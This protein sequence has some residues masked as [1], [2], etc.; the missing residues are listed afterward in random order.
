MTAGFV[1]L[2]VRYTDPVMHLGVAVESL[3]GIV[4]NALGQIVEVVHPEPE[5]DANGVTYWVRDYDIRDATKFAGL[6]LTV[7]WEAVL[8]GIALP[9]FP[10]LYAY[11]PVARKPALATV[12][13]WPPCA[14][15][16]VLFYEITRRRSDVETSIFVGRSFG[17][18][19]I[20]ET[21]FASEFE[22]RSWR[23]WVQQYARTPGFLQ[24]DGSDYAASGGPFEPTR[25][26]RA[27]TPVCSIS[28]RLV[29]I[30]GGPS[31]GLYV[32]RKHPEVIFTVHPK[33]TQ[34]LMGDMYI[35]PEDIVAN[36]GLDGY[37]NIVLLQDVIVEFRVT[38]TYFR[39]KFIVPRRTSAELSDLDI[40]IV[41]DY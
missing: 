26:W 8:R 3:S 14:D 19:Y 39:G 23:Y 41:R 31:V 5:V 34:Q 18:S 9:T 21:V 13:Q 16:N 38:S 37:F 30:M 15:P 17:P 22:A 24:L 33:Q 7:E 12:L 35:M 36:V 20:D 4:R 40:E 29:D 11:A 2:D 6:T 32:D 1:D 28:G 25:T 10:K 27:T